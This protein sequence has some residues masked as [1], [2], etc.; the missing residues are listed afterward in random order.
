[1]NKFRFL[2]WE[3]YQSSREIVILILKLVKKLPKEYRFE[4]GSQI[5]RAAFSIALNIAEGSAKSSDR[6][7]NRYLEISL[8]SI[9][10][11]VAALDVLK[12]AP[13]ITQ[14]EFDSLF[15]KLNSISSQLGG[16]KKKLAI[17]HSS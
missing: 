17:S 16:F 6:E 7:L 11:L 14:E 12:N 2:N 9:S 3:A 13:L 8:G 10:E 5:I 4:L 1:M 15:E